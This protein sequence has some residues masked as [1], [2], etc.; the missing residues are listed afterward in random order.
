MH[1]YIAKPTVNDPKI[2]HK[3]S[4]SWK[5][6][7]DISSEFEAYAFAIK[8]QEIATK[9]IQVKWHKGNTSNTIT[10]TKCRLC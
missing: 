7:K 5:R 6:N 1:G 10:D 8:D 3:T 9:Y 4:K 2:V